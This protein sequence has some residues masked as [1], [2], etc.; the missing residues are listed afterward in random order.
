MDVRE[1][2]VILFQHDNK[3]LHMKPQ[4][5]SL[6]KMCLICVLWKVQCLRAPYC[7]LCTFFF[8][9]KSICY[10]GDT[11]ALGATISLEDL[12]KVMSQIVGKG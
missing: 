2:D 10:A 8:A 1:I 4:C 11:S 5:V 6:M 3:K 12:T 7:A 9:E